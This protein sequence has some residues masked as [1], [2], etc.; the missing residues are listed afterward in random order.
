MGFPKLHPPVKTD[1]S[2]TEGVVKW[3]LSQEKLNL[4][5]YAFTGY[6]AEKHKINSDIT[7]PHVYPTGETKVPNT[8]H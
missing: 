4:W 2:I 6:A 8:I 1:N 3:T 5:I 7:G